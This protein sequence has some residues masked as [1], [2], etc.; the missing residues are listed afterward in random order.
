MEEKSCQNCKTTFTIEAEDFSFYEKM[1]VPP[2]TF[3]PWCRF[4]R[5]LV[6]RNERALFKRACS[7]CEKD[8]ISMYAPTASFPVYC[9][10]C[11]YSDSWDATSYGREYD[12][13]KPFFEQ[14]K[15][16][17]A[18]V[19]R[20]ALWSRNMVNSDYTNLSGESKNVYLSI[21]V[22]FGSE[23][24]FYS[25]AVDASFNIYDCHNIKNSD[26]C[27]QVIE[28]E[29]N[30]NSQHL[31]NSRNC[32]DSFFLVDCVNCSNCVLSSNL[33]NK[34]FY[35]RNKQYSKEEYFEELKKIDMGSRAIRAELL[36]EFAT[37]SKSAIYR[38][39]NILR[40]VD[41]TGNNLLNVKNAKHCFDMYDF[42]NA[43]YCYRTFTAKDF[44]DVDYA[45]G[46]ELIYE[47]TTGAK[48]DYNVKFSYSAMDSIRNADYTESCMIGT[49]LFG[50]ISCRGKDNTI[51]NKV[52]SKEEYA[53]L[54]EKIVEQMNTLPYIDARGRK[55][56][57]G[58][59]FPIETSA[60]FYNESPAQDFAPLRKEEAIKEGYPWR[61]RE[62]KHF[63]ITQTKDT[64]PDNI[65]EVENS[66]LND[67]VGCEH[68]GECL[69]Q[70]SR[71]F[72]LVKDELEYYRKNNIPL[73]T[74]C[75]N[76]RFYERFAQVPP[77]KLW[78]RTCVCSETGHDHDGNCRNVFETSYSPDRPEKVYCE[79]C[80]QKSVL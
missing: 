2:P 31:L 4:I 8:I 49:N 66:I 15:E 18:V 33:R 50:C 46:S 44:M 5:R 71:A 42:E 74:C 47:Y 43:A 16:L 65:K 23:N 21:S 70:C 55:Y 78:S 72:R 10:E 57:Y 45:L 17:S 24:V 29:K 6:W 27:Y 75:P 37:I 48:N 7:L 64:L 14:W 51:L 73:P 35:I 60:F 61:D 1:K 80:Y 34:E 26:G 79:S 54:R 67:V 63:N 32:I 62:E 22:I 3:C 58:E 38:F 52:Y 56:S 69:H 28:G 39:A 30:Y 76:C 77:P 36:K 25:K 12:F 9:R 20:L 11:W 68:E 59:F 13:S 41:S 53:T 40:S 19:P